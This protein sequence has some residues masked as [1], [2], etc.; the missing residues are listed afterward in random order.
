M[1][2]LTMATRL[3]VGGSCSELGGGGAR[4]IEFVNVAA[5]TGGA[6]LLLETEQNTARWLAAMTDARLLETLM[7]ELRLMF[8]HAPSP[9]TSA[10]PPQALPPQALP[11]QA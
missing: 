6:V 3:Q 5:Y 2:V 11:P 9:V 7:G 10:L 1:A 4:H 8:P